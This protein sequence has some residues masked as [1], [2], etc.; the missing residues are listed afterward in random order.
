M[1]MF[2]L[3]FDGCCRI[4][5]FILIPPA[6]PQVA[7]VSHQNDFMN[8]SLL[9]SFLIKCTNDFHLTVQADFCQANHILHFTKH[10]DPDQHHL[11]LNSRIAGIFYLL[12]P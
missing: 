7:H 6:F 8:L 5:H 2:H 9:S 10:R 4:C 11:F 3:L 12:Q 1:E